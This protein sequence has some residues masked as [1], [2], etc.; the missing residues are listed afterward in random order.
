MAILV[1][2]FIWLGLRPRTTG[3]STGVTLLVVTT[4]TLS[5]VYVFVLK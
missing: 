4:F 3:G 5:V 2:V 1:A